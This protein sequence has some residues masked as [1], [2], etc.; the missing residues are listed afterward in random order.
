MEPLNIR[1]TEDTPKVLFD[2]KKEVY[3]ISGR[4]LPEDVNQF[5]QPVFD[6]LNRYFLAPNEKT[7]LI[8]NLQYF[9]TASSKIIVDLCYLLDEMH[10]QGKQV[11]IKWYA[12]EEDEDILDAGEEFKENVSFPFEIFVVRE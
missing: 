7:T 6:W 2:A 1:S 4:S 11:N 8:F 12:E 10:E 5:Y 3:E 9:N